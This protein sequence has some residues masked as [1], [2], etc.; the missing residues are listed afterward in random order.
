MMEVFFIDYYGVLEKMVGSFF[1]IK[2]NENLYDCFLLYNNELQILSVDPTLE[3]LVGK[4]PEQW[5]NYSDLIQDMVSKSGNYD[6]IYNDI[7]ELWK[8]KTNQTI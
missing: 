5:D 7:L 1:K 8:R 6:D 2:Y 3:E 4:K